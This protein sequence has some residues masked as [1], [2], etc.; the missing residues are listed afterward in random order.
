MS[1]RDEDFEEM[2]LLV[3]LGVCGEGGGGEGKRSSTKN[4]KGEMII[5]VA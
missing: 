1:V 3:L 4:N 2:G 5:L